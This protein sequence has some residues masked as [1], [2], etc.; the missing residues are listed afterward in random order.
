M[1]F[2]IVKILFYIP[3]IILFPLRV[4][5]RKNLPKKGRV[6]LSG[7]HQTLSDAPLLGIRLHRRMHYM[8]KDTLFKNRFMNWF[9][10]KLNAYPVKQNSSDLAAIKHTI[11][12]LNN[13]QAVCIFPEGRRQQTSQDNDIKNGVAMLSI[14]TKSPIVPALFVAKTVM[15]RPN[16]LIVGK[17][18]NVWELLMLDDNV[19][20]NKEILDS[21]SQIISN[22]IHDLY[23]NKKVR[24]TSKNNNK[25]TD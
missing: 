13:E 5:G 23:P 9:F 18:I 4:V 11:R 17:P 7:N 15:F 3:I 25:K 20:I 24:K 19:K 16:K 8:A 1:I 2:Y 12:L 21:A 22:A 6:I 14:K 10:T